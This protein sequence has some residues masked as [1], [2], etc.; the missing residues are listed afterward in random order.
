MCVLWRSKSLQGG[1][2]TSRQVFVHAFLQEM[3]HA[4][5]AGH[6]VVDSRPTLREIK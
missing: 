6:A 3:W 1:Y 5:T 2:R 4:F